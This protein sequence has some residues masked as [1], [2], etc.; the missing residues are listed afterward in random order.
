[1]T[2]PSHRRANH[3]NEPPTTS[4]C[5]LTTFTNGAWRIRSLHTARH[6]L[7]ARGHTTQAGFTAEKIPHIHTKHRPIL[8]SDGP[9]HDEQRRQVARFFAP[10]VVA[11]YQ[12][13]MARTAE[14][15]LNPTQHRGHIH[16]DE[17]ALHYAVEVTAHIVG[18]THDR[19]G[20]TDTQRHQ[21]ITAMSHRLTTFFNQPPFDI[22]RKDLGRTHK[23]WLQAARNGLKPIIQFWWHDVRPALQQRRRNPSDDVMSHLLAHN[24]TTTDILI[25]A[26]TYG[27]AGMVTT[28]EFIC[29][30]AWHLL[31]NHDL[32]THYLTSD[33]PAR[34]ATLAEIIRLEPVVGHIWRRA[35]TDITPNPT[36]CIKA[37]QLIDINIRSANTDPSAVGENPHHLHPGR[38]TSP[39]I[40]ATGLAF[41]DGA[42][43]CPG[44]TLAL[45]ETDELL[46]RLLALKPH[47]HA[48]PTITWDELVAGYQIRNMHL[49]TQ[50]P[51]HPN[52]SPH[53]HARAT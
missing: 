24:A 6:I 37:G 14:T 30:A 17:L 13:L 46:T 43:A 20:E 50:K 32:R 40:D 38:T 48:P 33:Q 53:R 28:R 21:R 45:L 16:L 34:L 47:L 15:A 4:N 52:P 41:G 26:I 35:T 29:M 31:T 1:M 23:Q 5:P 12:P 10:T 22:T 8:I 11:T 36:T 19:P 18:L 2:T 3:P 49:L 39:G 9:L 42:H 7:R 27:T 44:K 25:E 51:P